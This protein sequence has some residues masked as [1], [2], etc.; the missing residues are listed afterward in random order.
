MIRHLLIV[1]PVLSLLVGPIEVARAQSAGEMDWRTKIGTFRVGI[2]AGTSPLQR[3]KRVQPFRRALEEVLGVPVEIF[4]AADFSTLI[5]AHTQSRIEYAVYSA[6]AFSA[7]WILCKCVEPLVAPAAEDGSY[8]F[9]SVLLARLSSA[10]SLTKLK[11]KTILIPGRD[12]FSGS[13]FPRDRLARQGYDPKGQGWMFVD[14]GTMEEAIAAFAEGEGDAL[15]GWRPDKAKNTTAQPRG[16][17]ARLGEVTRQVSAIWESERVVHGPHAIR[18]SLPESVKVLLLS[19]LTDMRE[20]MP[21]AYEAI[22]PRFPGGFRPVSMAD[23]RVVI[24]TVRKPVL[25]PVE[26]EQ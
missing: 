9:R 21:D 4:A 10:R 18:S 19:L 3:T 25:F 1:L 14:K 6:S 8:A 5:E 23:Y 2:V 26:S 20:A 17:L 7:A 13:I 22:E 11:G 12:S 24:D 15:F 16:T